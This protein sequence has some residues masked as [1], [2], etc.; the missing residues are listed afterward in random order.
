MNKTKMKI[1][2]DFGGLGTNK[3]DTGSTLT[4]KTS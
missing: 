3:G 1:R 2:V 4:R